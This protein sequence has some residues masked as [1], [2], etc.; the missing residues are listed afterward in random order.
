MNK[1]PTAVS[2]DQQAR[3]VV[4][5]EPFFPIGLYSVPHEESFAELRRAGFNVVHSYE[6]SRTCY[7]NPQ[8][9]ER[10]IRDFDGLGDA[11][12]AEYLKTA[13]DHDL[14]VLMSFNRPEGSS[15]EVFSEKG[16]E[17]MTER[18]VAL[19]EESALLGWYVAD[20]PDGQEFP[21]A[22]VCENRQLVESL[23]PGRPTMSCMCVPSK[24]E[25]YTETSEVLMYDPY[26]IGREPL[27]V[28][29]ENHTKLKRIVGPARATIGVVQAFDWKSYDW[30]RL[31]TRPPTVQELRCMTY[32]AIVSG[33]SG[34]FYFCYDNELHSNRAA[35]NPEGWLRL[36]AVAHELQTLIPALLS[37]RSQSLGWEGD[38]N[39]C[40]RVVGEETW[41]LAVNPSPEPCEATFTLPAEAAKAAVFNCFD[42]P[43]HLAVQDHW[44]M[45]F[46][47]YGVRA[48]RISSA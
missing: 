22:S 17:Q 38:I 23:D 25:E 14:M 42:S 39:A 18:I 13:A 21:L 5:G 4:G 2:I 9:Q 7:L 26:P 46:E 6:F 1:G 27:S 29:G 10:A 43:A 31:D 20:E 3:F 41:V 48:L 28:M 19:R 32:Q 11:A 24:F 16:R 45:S 37:P 44:Q 15:R 47:P 34:I 36:A 30:A 12:A 33:V 8:S 40:A 35:A